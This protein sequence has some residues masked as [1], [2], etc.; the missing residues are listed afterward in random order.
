MQDSVKNILY[1]IY[2]RM[3]GVVNKINKE[4][5]KQLTNKITLEK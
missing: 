3:E 1:P 4:K 2:I 5:N